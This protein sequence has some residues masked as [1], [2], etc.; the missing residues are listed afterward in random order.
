MFAIPVCTVLYRGN[1]EFYFDCVIVSV[2][3]IVTVIVIVIVIVIVTVIVIV[4]VIVTVS[5]LSVNCLVHGDILLLRLCSE[6]ANSM[7]WNAVNCCM[8]MFHQR[9]RTGISTGVLSNNINEH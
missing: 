7:S 1:P 9:K 5:N 4:V 8:A 3:V 6:S 2:I